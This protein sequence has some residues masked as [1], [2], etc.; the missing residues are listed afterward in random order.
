[1]NLSIKEVNEI[2]T[3]VISYGGTLKEVASESNGDITTIVYDINKDGIFV[4]VVTECDSYENNESITSIQFVKPM[5]KTVT[6]YES[7]K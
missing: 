4:K 1:M 7:I 6:D 5:V 2:L 3:K